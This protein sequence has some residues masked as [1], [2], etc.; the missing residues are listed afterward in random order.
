MRLEI[1]SAPDP[2]D[3][4]LGQPGMSGHRGPGPVRI[5]TRRRLQGRDNHILDLIQQDRGRTTRPRL[6][7]Q[8]PG[9]P[10]S[11]PPQRESSC[12]SPSRR[13]PPATGDAATAFRHHGQTFGSMHPFDIGNAWSAGCAE[14]CTSGVERRPGETPGGDACN[15]PQA[16]R[17]SS[18]RGTTAFCGG[19]WQ[20]PTTS[21]T[22]STK[23]GLIVE[24][25]RVHHVQLEL[26]VAPDPADRRLGLT[27]DL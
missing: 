7:G 15:A 16:N 6:V 19:L 23:N 13:R 2:P 26:E 14:T 1:E 12:S 27:P 9:L 17:H 24:L 5:G 3:R 22:F 11:A 20:S 4:G 10:V 21:T 25:E 8:H 18:T